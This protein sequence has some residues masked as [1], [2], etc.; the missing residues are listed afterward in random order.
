MPCLRAPAGVGG[1]RPPVRAAPGPS[2]LAALLYTSGTTGTPK[3]AM[4][5]HAN[6]VAMVSG[7]MAELPVV[8]SSDVV[9]HAGRWRT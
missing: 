5:T 3:A 8:D 7:L 2:D 9:M 6:W 1:S 4:V